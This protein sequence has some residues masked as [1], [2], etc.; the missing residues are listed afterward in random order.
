LIEFLKDSR[1]VAATNAAAAFRRIKAPTA[2][3]SLTDLARG[4]DPRTAEQAIAALLYQGTPESYAAIK[5][6]LEIGPTDFAR[7]FATRAILKIN[8]PNPLGSLTVLLSVSSWRARLAG[9]ETIAALGTPE[10]ARVLTTFLLQSDPAVRLAATVGADI[11][12]DQVCK[13]L[14]WG[15][16]NDSS[17]AVR[18]ASYWSLLRAPD[19]QY[20]AEGVKGVRD[21]SKA[22]RLFLLEAF[23]AEPSEAYRAALRIAVTDLDPEVRAA[24]LRA[25][26]KLPGPVAIE[27]VQNTVAD[28]D[29]RVA[30]AFAELAGAKGL[31][32]PSLRSA[33]ERKET[34]NRGV[35]VT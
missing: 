1:E 34:G 24:A 6:T 15:A 11:R 2:I 18:A 16:V 31:E 8:D 10:A 22:V 25:F 21:D 27:E 12:V 17:D 32:P 19:P 3:P 20:V 30:L 5:K 29:P 26:A 13:R 4:L 14:L 35:S 7:E 9:A 28:R 33:H 23:R